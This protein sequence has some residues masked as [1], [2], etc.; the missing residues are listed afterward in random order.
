M[1]QPIETAPR[2]GTPILGACHQV[3]EKLCWSPGGATDYTQ[4]GDKWVRYVQAAGWAIHM[5]GGVAEDPPR[6]PGGATFY[7]EPVSPP[8]HWMPLPEPPAGTP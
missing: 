3:V 7:I 5:N 2:D 4:I 1:W 6:E 8:T